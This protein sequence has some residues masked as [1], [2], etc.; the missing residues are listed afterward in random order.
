MASLDVLTIWTK[1][2]ADDFDV[3]ICAQ[4]ILEIH[5]PSISNHAQREHAGCQSVILRDINQFILNQNKDPNL[6]IILSKLKSSGSVT[7]G[8]CKQ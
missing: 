4:C 1:R 7:E 8:I 2:E 3:Y 5:E 6:A